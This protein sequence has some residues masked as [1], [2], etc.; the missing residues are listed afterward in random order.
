MK[1]LK[2]ELEHC[3]GIKRLEKE[4]DFSKDH[5]AAIYAPNGSM[6]SSL[7]QTF[8]DLSKGEKSKDKFFPGRPTKRS[9]TDEN[10]IELP[11]EM[12][13]VVTPYDKD[14]SH[15]EKT[16]TLLVNSELKQQYMQVVQE[17]EAEKELFLRTLK[18]Q[19]GSRKNLEEEIS[20]TFTKTSD[21]F[22]KALVRIKDEMGKQTEAPF[23]DVPYD[24]IFDERVLKFL[25]TK[26]VQAAIKEYVEKYNALLDKSVY[27]RRGFNYYNASTIA[28]NLAEHGFFDAKHTVSLNA[29]TKAPKVIKDRAELE[30]IIAEE[31]EHILNDPDLKGRYIKIEKLINAH[32]DLREFN[33][34]ICK[35]ESLLPQL[36]NLDQFKEDIWK[37]Y[38]KVKIDQYNR[39]LDKFEQVEKKKVEIE[40]EARKE[41]T[42]WETAIDK[43]NDRF[44]VP[45]TLEAKNKIAVMM[46]K[47]KL[48]KLGYTFVDGKDKAI[49]Q[50]EELLERLS[51]GERKA[52]YVLYIVFEVEQRKKSGQET[53]FVIDDVADSFDYKN[54]YAIIE[55]L[56]EISEIPNFFQIV[57]THNF[58]FFRTINSRYIRY[59]QCFMAV[60]TN[61]RTLIEKAHGI[62]NVFVNDWRKNFYSDAKK[63]IATIPFMR[64]LIEFT[65]NEDDPSYQKL[66]SLLHWRED[67]AGITQGELAKIFKDIFDIDGTIDE[68]IKV[69]DLLESAVGECLKAADGINFEN[70]IVLSIAIRLKAEQFMF[71]KIG[72]PS[73]MASLSKEQKQTSKLFKKFREKFPPPNDE[74]DI[75][76][77]V[78]LMTPETIHINSFMYEP[79]L[80]MSDWHLKELY[81]DVNN[82]T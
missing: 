10:G 50:R 11:P 60:K 56:M 81:G 64:N 36:E 54:K 15:T 4:I 59:D 52:L 78:M 6:K 1:K 29:G 34:F 27:F 70:K 68:G 40:E 2:I 80:D 8:L 45:F 35:N 69:M 61:D 57:L 13:F 21:G 74:I 58:D 25:G 5:A 14:F 82:L 65:R 32:A 31:R 71:R 12:I 53:I 75:L 51:T 46:G 47:E 24:Q 18:Q 76:E 17:V 41:I 48:L 37:S 42:L 22:Y 28:K 79:I 38:F 9:I 77:R 30:S 63:R 33:E 49:V 7:A 3:Y 73:L 26:D 44:D 67:S 16:S 39:L 72:D 19:S 23:A 43:F 20:T 66:T 62:R 55:Y